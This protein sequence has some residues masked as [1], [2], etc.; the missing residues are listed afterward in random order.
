MR[1]GVTRW[2]YTETTGMR[3]LAFAAVCGTLLLA[4]C[5]DQSQSPTEPP[6]A[7][8]PE[9]NFGSC[10][11]VRF[12]I[13]NVAGLI[14]QVFPQGTLRTQA[15]FQAA[16]VAILW[17]TCHP[18]AAR[19]VAVDF[20]KWIDLHAPSTAPASKVLQLKLAILNGV[21]IPTGTPSGSPGDFG[22]GTFDPNNPNKTL[23]KTTNG[24]AL[25]ELEPGAFTELTTIVLSR[26]P[27][28]TNLTNFDGNQFPPNFDYNAINASGN[29]VLG[30]GHPA[31][32]AFCLENSDFVT[33]PSSRGI[34]HNPVAGAPNFPFEILD[35]VDLGEGGR[36]DLA[37]AL[38]CGN[39]APT[40]AVVGGFGQGLPGFANAAWR[41]ARE[42]LAPVAQAV[43]LPE[44]LHAATLGTLPPP[45]GGKAPSLSPFKV[46]D[47]G[48][49]NAVQLFANDPG[50]V[51]HV[52]YHTTVIIDTCG[53][54]CTP[55]FFVAGPGN[56][57]PITTGIDITVT[58]VPENGATGTLSGHTTLTTS[59][60]SPFTAN[61]YDLTINGPNLTGAGD[62]HLLVS[63][64]GASSYTTGSFHVA[65]E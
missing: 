13:V 23:I 60:V 56:S 27:D 58:L 20:V 9:P 63:A 42:Y 19:K 6:A 46:V 24:T 1:V 52:L 40:T 54:G 62:Y 4:A 53:D 5:S 61:F 41:T 7:P 16:A 59:T 3:R 29:H 35:P 33:Y 25:I 49:L 38:H 64:P 50:E 31:I 21:G 11:P 36:S 15:L 43:F 2:P 44:A 55:E 39:L 12:P 48:G 26:N 37:A 8:A 32:I 28:A 34:G 51:G 22:V 30:T 57:G 14:V 10:Q 65:L 47:A 17:D 45:I 18:V